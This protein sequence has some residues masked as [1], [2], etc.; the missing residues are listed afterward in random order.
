[1]SRKSIRPNIAYDTQ[2]H[3]YYVTF[4]TRP[5]EGGP[6]HRISRCYP[7]MELAIQALDSHNAHRVLS[8]GGKRS[9]DELTLGQWLRYWLE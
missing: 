2:R 6:A 7:T 8:Q 1:M 4:R 9:I 5:P 3:C